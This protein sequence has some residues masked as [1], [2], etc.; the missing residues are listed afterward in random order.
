MIP[1]DGPNGHCFQSVQQRVASEVLN[2]VTERA[3]RKDV[4]D[5]H[6]MRH[7]VTDKYAFINSVGSIW[8]EDILILHGIPLFSEMSRLG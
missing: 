1:M 7:P 3:R 6:V 4:M 2:I 8:R 5:F